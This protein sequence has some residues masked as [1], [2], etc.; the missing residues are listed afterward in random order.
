MQ[1]RILP[2]A[3]L[4]PLLYLDPLLR[5]EVSADSPFARDE[6]F[7]SGPISQF[8]PRYPRSSSAF[9][10]TVHSETGAGRAFPQSAFLSTLFMPP[11]RKAILTVVTRIVDI[12]F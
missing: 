3:G 1:A 4:K 9:P 10:Q 11:E 7:R 5:I 2:I 8:P 12:F 6:T